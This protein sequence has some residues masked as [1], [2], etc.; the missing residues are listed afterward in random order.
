MYRSFARLAVI[1]ALGS[2]IAA[3]GAHQASTCAHTADAC[4]VQDASVRIEPVWQYSVNEEGDAG[5][6]PVEPSGIAVARGGVVVVAAYSGLVFGL[7][8]V[9][10]T[11]RWSMDL[12]E[13]PATPPTIDGDAVY[14]GVAD[15][16]VVSFSAATGAQRWSATLK[17]AV[18]GQP[19]VANG[20]VYV[21]TAEEAVVA[22]N[23]ANG[24]V[25]WTFRHPRTAEL[26]IRGGARPTLLDG[27]VYIGFSDGSFYK[28]GLDGKLVWASD[29]SR[30][31]RRMV[32]VDGTP[33]AYGN[34]IITSSHTGGMSGVNRD[35]GRIQ[36]TVERTGFT[37]PLL[38]EDTLI[39]STANGSIFWIDP[40]TGRELRE[41][42]LERPGLT[43]PL[44]FTENT[45]VVTDTV[46]GAFVLDVREPR[47]H[48]VFEPAVGISAQS[49]FYQD[50][51][52]VLTNR[53][54][55]YGLK[56]T[57]R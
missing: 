46:R 27:H 30:N 47:I 42:V 33:V 38:I 8:A 12:G 50:R 17:H 28:L 18:H 14:I 5:F 53:G 36:W 7:D 25:L 48:A 51:L 45:F 21:L 52:F 35:T 22:I 49:D 56:A 41:L 43:S 55:V 20:V 39:A 40:L 11:K 24:E 4:T 10:G 26:E 37:S 31:Q 15:G 6:R 13:P 29:L 54:M 9:A 19:T 34:L 32:D 44:H 2:T 16:R 3:C 23:E 1:G 57:L